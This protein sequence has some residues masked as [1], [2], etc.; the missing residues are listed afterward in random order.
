MSFVQCDDMVQNLSATTSHPAFRGSILPGD[1]ML[2]RFGCRPVAFRNVI[3]G[4]DF[5]AAVQDHITVWANFRE[6]FAQL[7]DD[8]LRTRMSR[9]VEMYDPAVPSGSSCMRQELPVLDHKEAVQ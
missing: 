7:L 4:I 9:N 2:F 8:S 1:W 6:S 5:R 3:S